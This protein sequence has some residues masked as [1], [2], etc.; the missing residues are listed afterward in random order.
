MGLSPIYTKGHFCPKGQMY[1]NTLNL[2]AELTS[3]SIL[4]GGSLLYK[5]TFARRVIFAQ[6]WKILIFFINFSFLLLFLTLNITPIV[7]FI[8]TITVTPNPYPRSVT[9]FFTFIYLLSCKKFFVKKFAFVHVD[10]FPVIA[11][12][13][14]II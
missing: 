12:I 1:T 4:H 9:Y 5:D 7:I 10:P 6:N 2:R 13:L 11:F 3:S 8:F 14:Y